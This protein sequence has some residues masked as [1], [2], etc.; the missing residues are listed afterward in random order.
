MDRF[1]ETSRARTT[2]RNDS[3]SPPAASTFRSLALRSAVLVSRPYSVANLPIH[4]SKD[5]LTDDI[6]LSYLSSV[7]REEV[8]VYHGE[9]AN[10]QAANQKPERQARRKEE[11]FQKFHDKLGKQ[12]PAG[13]PKGLKCLF[14]LCPMD[15][16]GVQQVA[17]RIENEKTS[18]V[19][20][21]EE[22]CLDRPAHAEYEALRGWRRGG[23]RRR[24]R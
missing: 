21:R 20:V 13:M 5:A 7:H 4:P 6:Y 15:R 11:S 12:A 14:V 1:V 2:R 10:Y 22:G 9:T 24:R 3:T 19:Q 8:R 16:E 18:R 23:R 17:G